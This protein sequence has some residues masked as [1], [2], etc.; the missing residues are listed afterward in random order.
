MD[1]MQVIAYFG[2]G[3]ATAD[4]LCITQ[5]AVSQWPKRVP[6][7]S[8]WWIEQITAGRLRV[9][10]AD[11]RMARQARPHPDSVSEY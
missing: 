5:S 11:Y 4:A 9:D 1:K 2:S 7:S 10:P 8:A 6:L 3:K